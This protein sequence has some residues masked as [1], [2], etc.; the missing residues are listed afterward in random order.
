MY[1]YM[2]THTKTEFPMCA[3]PLLHNLRELEDMYIYIYICIC[4]FICTHIQRQ[5]SPCA[6]HACYKIC[7][8]SRLCICIY[9]HMYMYIY[10]HIHTKTEFP[11]CASPLLQNLRELEAFDGY[12]VSDLGAVILFICI[13]RDIYV[14]R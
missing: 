14:Y 9:I 11:M 6:R 12:V 3:S 10:M 13:E 5:N 7:A 4:I 1:I 2:H 8:N